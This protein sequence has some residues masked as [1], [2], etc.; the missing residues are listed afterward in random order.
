MS[1]L[2]T[3]HNAY[4]DAAQIY[5]NCISAEAEHDQIAVNQEITSDAQ[6]AIADTQADIEKDAKPLRG[7]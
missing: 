1:A 2:I 6:K 7:R 4:V 5:M 3:Q